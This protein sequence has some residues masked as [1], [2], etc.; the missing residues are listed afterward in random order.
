MFPN[1]FSD[2]PERCTK[3]WAEERD[4][5]RWKN[6]GRDAT[7]AQTKTLRTHPPAVASPNRRLLQQLP[8]AQVAQIP[9]G[10]DPRGR[11]AHPVD[12]PS[13]MGEEEAPF[14]GCEQSFWSAIRLKRAVRLM[15]T[16][17]PGVGV[18]DQQLRCILFELPQALDVFTRDLRRKSLLR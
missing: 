7:I 17:T 4:I 6:G 15:K 10:S 3:L 2:D 1:L 5:K 8:A 14:E 12:R 11:R 16:H 13:L 18:R 9:R